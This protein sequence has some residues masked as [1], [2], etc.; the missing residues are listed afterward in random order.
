SFPVDPAVLTANFVNNPN[1]RAYQ[2]RAYAN[3]YTIPERIYQYTASVQQDLGHRYTATA[4]YMGSQ[5]RNLFLRSVANQIVDVVTNSNPTANAFVIREFSIVQRDAAGNVTGVQNPFA[6]VDYK[7]SGGHD[8][9]NAMMLQLSRRAASGI[10]LN[11]QYTLGQSKG[12][13]AGSNEALTSGNLA[14]KLSDFDYDNGF[15]NF[16][17]RHTFNLSLLYPLPYGRGRAFGQNASGVSQALLG[18]WDIGGIVNARRGVPVN[19]I[20]VRP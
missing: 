6:E 20:I 15:N 2:P 8:S 17:V 10:S 5:G 3:D 1:N 13:T 14:R 4:A 7:T 9:Y 12:N 16:D 18:G 11:V 19:V